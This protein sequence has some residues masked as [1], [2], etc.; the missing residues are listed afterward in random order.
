MPCPKDYKNCPSYHS[1]APAYRK[2][3]ID[4][5]IG[6]CYRERKA[7]LEGLINKKKWLPIFLK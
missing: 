5:S 1:N 7:T 6:E 2:C 4:S 3:I